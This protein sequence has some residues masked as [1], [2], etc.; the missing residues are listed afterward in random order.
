MSTMST[1][2]DKLEPLAIVGMSWRFPGE[3]NSASGFWDILSHGRSAKSRI[4]EDR[5]NADAY[6]HP[7]ADRNGSITT[8]EGHFLKDDIAAFDAPFFS[9][10]A[11]EADGMDPQHRFLLEVT[12]EA[13]ENAGISIKSVA[14]SQTAVM[15]GCFTSD[16]EVLSGIEIN[17]MSPYTSTGCGASML[18]NRLS[19]FYDL[20]G[21]ADW[22]QQI[23][24]NHPV[25]KQQCCCLSFLTGFHFGSR[26][27]KPELWRGLTALRFLSPDGQCHSFDSRANGYGRGEGM[28]VVVI[29][30]LA[31]ALKD[32]DVI[33]AVIRGTGTNQDGKTS[34]ITVPSAEAQINLIKSTYEAA[35][36]DFSKTTYFEAHGTGTPVGDPLEISAIGQTIGLAK[37]ELDYP[38]LV[39]SVKSNIGHL[40]GA[41]GIAGVIKTVLAL[42]QGMIPAVHGFETPNPRLRL[43]EWNIKIPSELT[44][45]PT[46]GLRRASVNS[47]GYGGTNAH[48]ILDDALHYLEERNLTGNHNTQSV[49]GT[50][51]SL[52]TDSGLSVGEDESLLD[53][54][55][56]VAKQK[57]FVFSA[58]E[59][60]GLARLSQT[61]TDF[62]RRSLSPE[63]NELA[64]EKATQIAGLAYTLSERRTIFD[65]RSFAVAESTEDLLASLERSLPQLPRAVKSPS[66]AFVFTGQG[67]QWYAM[68]RELQE[69]ETF[70]QSIIAADEYLVS[71]GCPWS[72]L[73]ELN[74]PEDQSCIH[75]PRISQPLCTI[76]QVALVNL[77]SHWGLHPRAVVG[78]SSGEIAAAYAAGALTIQ[79]AWKIAYFR[80]VHSAAVASLLP[81]RKGSMMAASISEAVAQTYIDR[82]TQGDA[83]VACIN[84]PQSVTISG[85]FSAVAEMEN[86]LKTD[87]IWCRKLKVQ[88]AYHSPHMKAIAQQYLESIQDVLPTESSGIS[89]FSSVTGAEI[90]HGDLSSEYWVKNL[91]SPVRFSEAATALLNHCA[92]KSRRGA[93][94]NINALI[95]L[96]PHSALQGPLR[97]ILAAASE[98]YLKSVSYTSILRRGADAN[99]TALCAA[100]RLWSLGFKLSLAI[101]NNASESPSSSKALV[102][103]PRYPFNHKR[104]YWHESRANLSRRTRSQPRTDLLG[105]PADD[106]NPIAPRWKNFLRP[107]ETPWLMDHRIQGMLILPGAAMLTMVLEACEQSAKQSETIHGYQFRDVSFHRPMVFTSPAAATE[108]SMQ[109]RPHQTGT[110]ANTAHWTQFSLL[111]LGA[112]GATIEHCSGLVKIIYAPR[113]NE[114]DSSTEQSREW[115]LRRQEYLSIQERPTKEIHVGRLYDKLSRLG[116]Q[117]GPLF[118]NLTRISAGDGFGFGE[119]QIPDS[120]TRMPENFE[121]PTPIHPV[122]LDGVFQMMI[123]CGTVKDNFSAMAPSFIESLYVSASLPRDPGSLLR[124][125]STLGPKLRLQQSGSVFMSDDTWGEPKIVLEGFVCKELSSRVHRAQRKLCTQLLWKKD[126]ECSPSTIHTILNPERFSLDPAIA[127]GAS[128]CDQAVSEHVTKSLGM[129]STE[130]GKEMDGVLQKYISWMRDISH[131]SSSEASTCALDDEP[132]RM[133]QAIEAVGSQLKEIMDPGSDS[134]TRTKSLISWFIEDCLG[135]S[136]INSVVAEL[137]DHAGFVS[138]NIEILEIGSG[139]TSCAASVLDRLCNKTWGSARLK[140]YVLTNRTQASLDSAQGSLSDREMVDFRLLD[141]GQDPKVQ[142]FEFEKFDYIIFNELLPTA[143]DLECGMRNLRGLLKNDGKLLLGAITKA[144]LRTTFV[145]GL[146]PRWWSHNKDDS[147]PG[148]P[149][150]EGAWAGVLEKSGFAG[151]QHIIH[152]SEDANVHQLSLMVSSVERAISFDFSEVVIVN[153]DIC[154][155]DVSTFAANFAGLLMKLGL[156]VSQRNWDT[157]GDVSGKVLVSF[158]EIDSPVLGEM[159]EPVFEVVKDMA[160]NSAGVLWITRGGQVSGPFKPYSG[161]CT[162]FFRALRSESPEK[163]LGT[164]DLSLGLDLQSEL[165]AT[166]VSEVFDSLFRATERETRD[167]EFAEDECC[168]YVPRLVE[169][170][171]LN[172]AMGA[173]NEKPR[174]AMEKLLQE[175]RPLKMELGEPGL[176]N[177]FQFVDDKQFEEPLRGDYVEVKVQCT[178]LNFVDVMAALG[179][180]PTPT[181][182]CEVGGIITKIGP[183]VT[184]FKPGDTVAGMLQGSFGT[185]VRIRQT[186]IQ[187]VPAHMTVEAAVTVIT[188]FLTAWIGLV[189]RARLRRG[190]TA[191][192]H[193]GAGGVGQ[194]AIQICQHLGVEVYTTVGSVVKKDL[195]MER[196]RIPGDHIFNSR[197]GNFAQG[198]M[199]MTKRRG[200]D[201]VLNSLSGEF[202][203]QSWHCLADFGRFIEIGKRDLLGNTGLD[204]QPFLRGVS[205]MGVN[206]EQFHPTSAAHMELSEALQDIFDL[207]SINKLRELYPITI[208]TYS[209]VEQAFRA[210]QSGKVLGKI[211][212]RASPD[213]IVPVLPR[214]NPSFTLDANATYLLAGGLGG[215]GRSIA[216]ML[217]S[218]GARYL[219]FLSRSGDSKPEAQAFLKQLSRYGCTAKAYSCDISD[220]EKVFQAIRQCSSELPPIKGLVQCSMVLKDGLFDNMS[221]DDWTACTRAKIQGS[222]NLH[223]ALPKH[224]DFFVMLSSISGIIG[225]PGQANYSAANVYEDG[226]AHFRRRQGL[227]AT[228]LDLGAVR[229]IGYLAESENA[230][231]MSHLQALQVSE[232]DIHSLLEVV[233]TRRRLGDD[234]IPAQV[235]TGLVTGDEMEEVIQRT[236]WA[237][238]VKFS[239]LWKTS[240]SSADAGVLAGLDAFTKA[241]SLVA[242]AAI[243][244]DIIISRIAQVLMMPVE[245]ISNTQPLHSYGVDSLVA[246]EM[247]AWMAKEFQTELSVFDILS[248]IPL[249]G[250]AMKIVQES[251][252]LPDRLKQEVQENEASAEIK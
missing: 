225:N 132:P 68:G 197:D 241:E 244:E 52:S 110:R 71:L 26:G 165:A 115:E 173:L 174:P 236:S 209:E 55:G 158:W 92:T 99:E 128:L 85:D 6:Y 252:L 117:L 124:G 9:M 54:I 191:L 111:S 207:L 62:L 97:D 203:R 11:A 228:A 48:L 175:E 188:A 161:V 248:S 222:W 204:M 8:K 106:H 169:D 176:L 163:R 82:V 181:L 123:C 231:N 145:L 149:L 37:G 238:D 180:V 232:T 91:L 67:A 245:D 81:G 154:A 5:F 129:L 234:G 137:I 16:Y 153:P 235:V 156:S 146:D 43:E 28:G 34:G 66:C 223:E 240:E 57:L 96:G 108:T 167:Y 214:A 172:S 135:Q 144:Q 208:Y 88:T 200:V 221:Y 118:Q 45:W 159:S 30:P 119:L 247:R 29:K 40:E 212:V 41:S 178:G 148:F 53:K 216:D 84:S 160:L 46:A 15:V 13:F 20:Q 103:L 127:R 3:A 152:D 90:S 56:N 170:P 21:I 76:L 87:D 4:P 177:T 251:N 79:S 65:W 140:K 74:R 202:L 18:A 83:V 73:E 60:D 131:Q 237:R 227:E 47:F 193:S 24:I 14:G 61:Y 185:H 22:E 89:F 39:G 86:M 229:D 198:V 134:H 187:H 194:A 42:E 215:I 206:L 2:S 12:Y 143:G 50:P 31:D 36:L 105:L 250:L 195:L 125:F 44:Q 75:E 19:W 104:R 218:H 7:S 210:L 33:R 196:Y 151:V 166:L 38:L 171:A 217:Q 192:I 25:P 168:L 182:G 220:R 10:T 230:A 32:N 224:L 219:A 239:I 49:T 107:V 27:T 80:G 113:P 184:K 102:N 64:Y 100:G 141:I 183:A 164:F 136:F 155:T 142:G 199:R 213:D 112:D 114:I 1:M 133:L 205:Y 98:S 35:G 93:I 150:D 190:E 233:I 78:H 226:L 122:V 242:A 139:S 157:I 121:Y 70:K 186:I 120:A 130:V 63:T 69:Y 72:V 51:L 77:L 179:Q 249:S 126:A 94:T 246:V 162:G 95:E 109:L 116:L 23:G 58:P 243:V 138:P 17:A 101:V 59:Q 201:V 189:S 147:V 211:V